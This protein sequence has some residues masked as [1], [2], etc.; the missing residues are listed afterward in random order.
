MFLHHINTLYS[1][2][3]LNSNIEIHKLPH[4]E[5]NINKSTLFKF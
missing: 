1:F 5:P 3:N 2:Y 4:S